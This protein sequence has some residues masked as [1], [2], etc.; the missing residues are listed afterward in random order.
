[1]PAS[2]RAH[3]ERE[4]RGVAQDLGDFAAD[5]LAGE[6]LGNRGFAHA[7]IA[8]EERI[9]LLAAAEHLDRAQHL[10][11]TA[12]Q[13]I[14]L[15][16]TGLAI[17]VD[18]IRI[19]CVLLALLVL[20]RFRL[21][22]LLCTPHNTGFR[23][24]GT[25]RDTVTDVL[26]GIEARH[27]LLL[28]EERCMA[29]ALCEDRDQHVGAGDFFAA[30]RLNVDHGAMDHALKARRRRGFRHRLGRDRRK[31]AVQ[32]FR[33][34]CAQPIDIDIAGPHHSGCVTIFDQGGEQ[35][36]QR[37]IFMAALVGMLERTMKGDL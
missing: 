20:S 19:E 18:A 9:V 4:D 37:R 15:A 22:V 10:R 31:L 28:Q 8:D 33:D 2:K 34:A 32:I 27:V 23:H 13:R 17:E 29:F 21:L 12:D 11:L 36:L 16:V 5:D 26:D 7:G 25:F 6:T 3:V 35:M 1:M 14:D 24:A 30:R